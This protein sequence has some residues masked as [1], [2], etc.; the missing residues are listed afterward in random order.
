MPKAADILQLIKRLRKQSQRAARNGCDDVAFD[1]RAASNYLEA[2]ASELK[3]QRGETR[4][5]D[6]AH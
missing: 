2:F 5:G 1:L 4:D 6:Q 3:Q